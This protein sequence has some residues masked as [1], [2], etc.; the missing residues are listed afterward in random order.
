VSVVLVVDEHSVYR[1]G[2]R[3]V[4]QTRFHSRVVE[5]SRFE[6]FD[7]DANFDLILIDPGC[8]TPSALRVER[9]LQPGLVGAGIIFPVA[10]LV[11]SRDP[12]PSSST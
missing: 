3:D 4:I 2:L 6:R 5:A 10:G 9:S 12:D 1:S 11:G 8:L 7:A